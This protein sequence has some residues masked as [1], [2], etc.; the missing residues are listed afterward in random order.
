MGDEDWT[1]LSQSQRELIAHLTTYGAEISPAD[2][3]RRASG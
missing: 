3:I 2:N 1:G